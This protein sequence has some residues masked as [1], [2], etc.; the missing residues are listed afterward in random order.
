MS[1]P[2]VRQMQMDH[3]AAAAAGQRRTQLVSAP[4]RWTT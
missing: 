2:A 1:M 3:A 4:L